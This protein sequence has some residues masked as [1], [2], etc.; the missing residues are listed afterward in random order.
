MIAEIL[1]EIK[2]CKEKDEPQMKLLV[3]KFKILKGIE[4]DIADKLNIFVPRQIN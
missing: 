3:G 2:K 1:E 4:Q